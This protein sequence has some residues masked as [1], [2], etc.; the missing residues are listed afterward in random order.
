M[1]KYN[2]SGS[3]TALTSLLGLDCAHSYTL[4]THIRTLIHSD[5]ELFRETSSCVASLVVSVKKPERIHYV[6]VKRPWT[7]PKHNYSFHLA[8]FISMIQSSS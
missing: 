5:F 7:E 2:Y 8:G 1:I 4:H 6:H 3:L